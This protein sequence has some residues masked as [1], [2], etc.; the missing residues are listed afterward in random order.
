MGF[1]G[2]K[3]LKGWDFFLGYFPTTCIKVERVLCGWHLEGAGFNHAQKLQFTKKEKILKKFYGVDI[4][5]GRDSNPRSNCNS[6]NEI[7][8]N[9]QNERKIKKI[10][11]YF[12]MEFY[13]NYIKYKSW[14][15]LMRF[16]KYCWK[17][18]KLR[19]GQMLVSFEELFATSPDEQAS[20]RTAISFLFFCYLCL[21]NLIR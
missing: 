13:E 4:W 8:C 15:S 17:I 3:Q 5:R 1:D 9:S 11:F 10:I 6:Q 20:T 19:F 16:Q 18:Q 12:L 14:N 7:K 2:A 21:D